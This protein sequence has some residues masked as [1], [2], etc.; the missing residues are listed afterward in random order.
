MPQINPPRRARG[1]TLRPFGP[2]R[3]VSFPFALAMNS[4]LLF[5]VPPALSSLPSLPLEFRSFEPWLLIGTGVAVG[6]VWGRYWHLHKD[7][8]EHGT[9]SN[10]SKP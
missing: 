10:N 6:W 9:R 7:E 8:Q 1:A 2:I 4:L 3:S 5:G